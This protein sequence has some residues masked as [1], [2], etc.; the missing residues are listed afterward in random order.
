MFRPEGG[1]RRGV[2][3]REHALE[4]RIDALPVA[5]KVEQPPELGRLQRERDVLV[6][7]QQP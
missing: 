1:G 4:D 6:R 2:T 5:S 3:P 7:L